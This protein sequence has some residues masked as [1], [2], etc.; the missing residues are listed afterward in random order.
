MRIKIKQFL[1]MLLCIT[2]VVVSFT[3]CEGNTTAKGKEDYEAESDSVLVDNIMS[4]IDLWEYVSDDYTKETTPREIEVSELYLFA[5]ENQGEYYFVTGY[6][7]PRSYST[8]ELYGKMFYLTE[9]SFEYIC[10]SNDSKYKTMTKTKQFLGTE[11]IPDD[12]E[13]KEK[14]VENLIELIS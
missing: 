5:G 13:N 12:A 1:I 6:S 3:A 9:D 7:V 11:S 4:D 8:N 14:Y 2:L 10:T